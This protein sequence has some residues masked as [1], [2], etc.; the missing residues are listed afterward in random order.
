MA[1]DVAPKLLREYTE[2]GRDELRECARLAKVSAEPRVPCAQ[3][4]GGAVPTG[5]VATAAS[6]TARPAEETRTPSTCTAPAVVVTVAGPEVA[7]PPSRQ[8]S[9]RKRHDLRRATAASTVAAELGDL[10][11]NNEG[12]R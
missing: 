5:G 12:Q 7:P 3:A 4:A 8:V 2:R 1:L 10:A 9:R 11:S 6:A